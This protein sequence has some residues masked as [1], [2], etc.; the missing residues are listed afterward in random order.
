M[1]Y[2]AQAAISRSLKAACPAL[3]CLF[4]HCQRRHKSKEP[5]LNTAQ[6]G[7]VYRVPAFRIIWKSI[8][9]P[10]QKER[11]DLGSDTFKRACDRPSLALGRVVAKPEF[12]PPGEPPCV[13][14]QSEASLHSR[15]R[16]RDNSGRGQVCK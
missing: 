14:V 11:C 2:W 13:R 3:N 9:N 10:L 8:Q 7:L 16:P 12:W 15:T 5:L 4:G 1:S 6:A